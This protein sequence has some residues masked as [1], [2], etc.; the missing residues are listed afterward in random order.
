MGW[1]DELHDASFRG[2]AFE[3]TS[4]SAAQAKSVA[5]HQAPYSNTASVE[6]MGND[7]RRLS[8][9]AMYTGD[10]Y[11]TWRN[12]LEAALLQ[13][14]PGELI[15]PTEGVKQVQVLDYT[16]NEDAENPDYCT[17]SIAFL[18]TETEKRQLFIPVHVATE[19]APLDILKAPA[20]EFTKAME[21]LKTLYPEKYFSLVKTVRDGLQNVRNGLNLAK[22]TV[23]NILSPET[24]VTGLVDDISRLVNFDYSISAISQWRDVLKRVERF[25]DVFDHPDHPKELKQLWRATNVAAVVG[26][27][28]QIIKTVRDEM[29]EQQSLPA[30]NQKAEAVMISMTPLDLAQVRAKTRETIQSAIRAEREYG[31]LDIAAASFIQN[32]KYIADQVHQQ[33]QELIEIRPPIIT[34][35]VPVPCTF[36][37]LAHHLYGDM[38]RAAELH[39]LN[40]DIQNPALLLKGMEVTVYAR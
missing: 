4:V 30:Q 33:I 21:K 24:W 15:H 18:V 2:V 3:C 29:L 19:I 8:V 34:M 26:I 27:T 12:A 16:V 25:T 11:L 17:F 13:T 39:R 31:S 6:D 32:Y 40:Q 10:D 22:K 38:N 1:K 35:T 14:G 9:N 23:Q 5:I 28:Q 37:W 7:A 36:H 20:A